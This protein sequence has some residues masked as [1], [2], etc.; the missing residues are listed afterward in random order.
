MIRIYTGRRTI[1]EPTRENGWDGYY[2]YSYK[3][4]DED[5]QLRNEGTE[6]FNQ[7]RT[8][9]LTTYEVRELNGRHNVNG[10]AMTEHLAYIKIMKGTS[11]SKAARAMYG[12]R[13]ARVV[14][15]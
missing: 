10:G 1:T 7:A 6:D 13:V 9:N 4:Y 3:E 15:C 11:P 2:E 14:K 8:H 12:A 5:G